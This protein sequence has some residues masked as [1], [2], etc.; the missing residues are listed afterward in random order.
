M[1]AY[2]A[3][4]KEDKPLVALL[5]RRAQEF[6]IR[7]AS[8]LDQALRHEAERSEQRLSHG[9]S[10]GMGTFSERNLD[11]YLAKHLETAAERATVKTQVPAQ[12]LETLTRHNATQCGPVLHHL[13]RPRLQHLP[14]VLPLG[15]RHD[16]RLPPGA[17]RR[18][19]DQ[20]GL[21]SEY[22]LDIEGEPRPRRLDRRPHCREC[23]LLVRQYRQPLA[24]HPYRIRHRRGILPD[25]AR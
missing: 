9:P 3:R 19:G 1:D 25:R 18:R 20:P 11:R 23:R 16:H 5:Q 22:L 21:H 12:V 2:A 17:A 6:G 4:L 10:L 15:R 14:F 7:Q 24:P 8:Q 13:P